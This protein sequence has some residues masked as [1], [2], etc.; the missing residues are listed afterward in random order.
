[1][2]VTIMNAD[3]DFGS[4]VVSAGNVWDSSNIE[5]CARN[6]AEK[7]CW[8]IYSHVDPPTMKSFDVEL[9]VDFFMDPVWVDDCQIQ[10]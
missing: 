9:R 5:R 3:Y 7:V 4:R 8:W 1:M 10:W 6:I 2:H